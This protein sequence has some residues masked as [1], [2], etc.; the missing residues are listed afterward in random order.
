MNVGLD[1]YL[2]AFTHVKRANT[3]YGLAPHKP[4]LLLT[5]VELIEKGIVIDNRFEVNVDLVGLF[6]E[7][8]R[9][10][11]RTS[12]QSDFTQPFYYLQSDKAAGQGFWHLH[13]NPGFQINAHIKSVKTL[14]EVVA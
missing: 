5:L 13:P 10:L 1:T 6:Q 4:I 2:S 11:V 14:S 7:N 3:R 12:H 9:L 8:W